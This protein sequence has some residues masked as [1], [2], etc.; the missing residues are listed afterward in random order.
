M[1]VLQIQS[2][3]I[4]IVCSVR[5]AN[6]SASDVRLPQYLTSG[7]YYMLSYI[8]TTFTDDIAQCPRYCFIARSS[9]Q[10]RSVKRSLA[11]H[12]PE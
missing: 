8:G 6:Y 12:L 1:L 4:W 11:A 7:L 10:S 3:N 2:S 9:K 5:M